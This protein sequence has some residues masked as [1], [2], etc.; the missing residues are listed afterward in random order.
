[1]SSKDLTV[2]SI[3]HHVRDLTLP[4]SIGLFFQTMYNTVDTYYAGAH[5]KTALAA[6][7]FS[8]PVFLLIIA[9]SSGL[10]RASAGLISNALGAKNE[11]NK[12]R[13]IAQGMSIGL[14]LSAVL[15]IIGLTVSQ[16]IFK[17]MGADGELLRLAQAYIQP[18]FLG[19]GFFIFASLCNAILSSDGD[20]KTYGIVLVIGFFLNLIFDPWFMKGGLGIPALGVA[21]IAW[22]TVLIQ[23][24]GCVFLLWTVWR[25]GLLD[26]SE[27]KAFVPDLVTW[28][29][30][31]WQALPATFNLISISISFFTINLF[32]KHFGESAIAAYTATI[33]IEQVALIPTFGLYA[34]IMALVGQ[35]NGAQKYD[36]IYQTMRWCAGIGVGAASFMAGL[37]FIFSPQLMRLFTDD[38]E[39]IHLGVICLT[40][41]API[42]WTYILSATHIAMLQALKRPAYGFFEAITRKVILPIPILWLLI[43]YFNKDIDWIWYCNAGINLVMTAVTVFY[44]RSVLHRLANE[45]NSQTV[46]GSASESTT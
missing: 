15:V 27:P 30:I 6:V 3:P 21:G 16:P 28:R 35:N 24:F 34:A 36:R 25:R 14:F 9:A 42:L 19:T 31:V 4:A 41:I 11:A 29:E 1:M 46:G 7:G 32:L 37:M 43:I 18:I 10:S 39:V 40:I 8:F 12:N 26:L 13:Y 5:S 17:T 20:T 22:A 33:R 45:T 44:A 38:K 23:F 2:G